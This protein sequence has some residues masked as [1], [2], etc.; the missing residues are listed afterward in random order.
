MPPVPG[1][2]PTLHGSD[3]FVLVVCVASWQGKHAGNLDYSRGKR[4]IG[5]DEKHCVVIVA[6]TVH[7][8]VRYPW[9][10]EMSHKR[11]STEMRCVVRTGS[12]SLDGFKLTPKTRAHFNEQKSQKQMNRL[13]AEKSFFKPDLG[14][15]I[16]L[17]LSFSDAKPV[18]YD[19]SA[20][21]SSTPG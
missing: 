11:D 8:A 1:E 17:S 7:V 16:R 21:L 3:R 14:H 5:P 18:N 19:F 9:H 20:L 10:D 15:N 12:H 4:R 6:V 13:G 2:E